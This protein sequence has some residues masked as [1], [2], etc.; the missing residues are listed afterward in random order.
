VSQLGSCQPGRLSSTK[1]S[2]NAS[3]RH[4]S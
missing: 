2:A 4:A 3:L 1:A